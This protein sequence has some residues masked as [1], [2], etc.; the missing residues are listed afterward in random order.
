MERLFLFLLAA[1]A[2]THRQ[3][4]RF[5]PSP[6]AHAAQLRPM[7]LAWWPSSLTGFLHQHPTRPVAPESDLRSSSSPNRIIHFPILF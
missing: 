1:W 7:S 4:S 3:P 2:E 6:T 5:P